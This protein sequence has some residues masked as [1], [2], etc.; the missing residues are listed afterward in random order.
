MVYA[1]GEIAELSSP[2]EDIIAC[3]DLPVMKT[4]LGRS[5]GKIFSFNL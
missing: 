5:P 3:N 1:F 4:I 2:L